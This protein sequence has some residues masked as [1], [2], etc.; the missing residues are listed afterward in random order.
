MAFISNTGCRFLMIHAL[1]AY[2]FTAHTVLLAGV[3]LSASEDIGEFSPVLMTA[4][5]ETNEVLVFHPRERGK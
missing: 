1:R 5:T 4:T 2:A 3:F